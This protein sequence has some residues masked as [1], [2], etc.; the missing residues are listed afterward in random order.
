MTN[1]ELI[2]RKLAFIDVNPTI[3]RDVV[4]ITW[5]ISKASWKRSGERAP[6]RRAPSAP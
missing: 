5:E 1:R 3:V 2:E 6:S 4:E